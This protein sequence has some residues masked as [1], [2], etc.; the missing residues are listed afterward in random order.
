MI[1]GESFDSILNVINTI[2]QPII[3]DGEKIYYI[4]ATKDDVNLHTTSSVLMHLWCGF[5][6][7]IEA[8]LVN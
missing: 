7:M 5:K 8:D 6:Q 3:L 1:L 4:R 2:L